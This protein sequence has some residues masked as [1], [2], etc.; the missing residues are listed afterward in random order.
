MLRAE[1]GGTPA[2]FVLGKTGSEAIHK[3]MATMKLEI[4]LL[5]LTDAMT[6][7]F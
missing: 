6:V 4:P 7:W 1:E 3:T 5:T 2:L